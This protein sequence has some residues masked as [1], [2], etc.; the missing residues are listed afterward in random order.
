MKGAFLHL[1]AKIWLLENGKNL[2]FAKCYFLPGTL[3]FH[4]LIS[5]LRVGSNASRYWL[6][7]MEED[8]STSKDF[9]TVC[10]AEKVRKRL[11]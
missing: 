8:N 9:L 2:A 5:P 11:R 1:V 10:L 7:I 4:T 6:V 3:C